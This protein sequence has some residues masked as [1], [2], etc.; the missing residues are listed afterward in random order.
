M[1]LGLWARLPRC[2]ARRVIFQAARS[3]DNLSG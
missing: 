3:V 2:I 1:R